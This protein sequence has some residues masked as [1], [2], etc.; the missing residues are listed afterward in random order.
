VPL[1]FLGKPFKGG[2]IV[3]RGRHYLDLIGSRFGRLVV[4]SKSEIRKSNKI[5]WVCLC[6]CG[7][8][9]LVIT[10]LLRDG[11]VKSCG[12]Y[13]GVLRRAPGDAASF[14]RFYSQYSCNAKRRNMEFSL[15]PE[16]FRN[17]T[18]RACWYCGAEPKPNYARYLNPKVIPVPYIGNGIDRKNNKIG[19]TPLNC[20]SCCFTCNGMKSSLSV[21]DFINHIHNIYSYF[22]AKQ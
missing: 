9:H 17:I 10:G 22:E 5:T 21:S 8:T 1:T 16:E 20:V 13:S 7:N 3:G 4:V 6:D 14:S 2:L 18:S 11:S 15:S 19:Y 12:C